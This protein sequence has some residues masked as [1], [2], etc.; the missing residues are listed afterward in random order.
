[1][2]KASL[3]LSFLF[4]C[5]F[6][7]MASVPNGVTVFASQKEAG[8]ISTPKKSYYTKKFDVMVANLSEKE[9]DL[10]KY[11]FKAFLGSWLG[12]SINT[13]RH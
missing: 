11:C 2:K 12:I 5:S 10:S 1:M 3:L 8:S 13:V 6:S 4:C 7:I 9:L